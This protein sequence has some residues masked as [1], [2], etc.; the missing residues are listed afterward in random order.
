[1]NSLLAVV[2]RLSALAGDS[3]RWRPLCP[4]RSAEVFSN[5]AT[6][7]AA[8]R[9]AVYVGSDPHVRRAAVGG[10]WPDRKSVV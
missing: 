1:M 5:R 8:Q 3:G 4:L 7:P 9:Q 6:V 10:A 2:P